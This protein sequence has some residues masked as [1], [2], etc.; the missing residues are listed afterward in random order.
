MGLHP[1]YYCTFV[2]AVELF[3]MEIVYV[4]IYYFVFV[5]IVQSL[6]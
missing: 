3:V 4:I 6:G 1:L 2:I 5:F